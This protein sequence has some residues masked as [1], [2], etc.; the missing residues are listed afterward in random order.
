MRAD[1]I[2]Q[3]Q[4]L[5]GLFNASRFPQSSVMQQLRQ[6]IQCNRLLK[7]IEQHRDPRRAGQVSTLQCLLA[8]MHSF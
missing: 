4:S 2:L 5:P 3:P 1:K 8:S 6:L 7:A